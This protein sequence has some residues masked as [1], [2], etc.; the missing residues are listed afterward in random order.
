VGI[1]LGGFLILF[2]SR[3]PDTSSAGSNYRWCVVPNSNLVASLVGVA[4]ISPTDVW[5]VGSNNQGKTFTEHWNG[6]RWQVVASPNAGKQ[7]NILNAVVAVSTDDVW[8]VGETFGYAGETLVEHWNG[9]QW[10]IVSSPNRHPESYNNRLVSVAAI[11]ANDIWA[12][13]ESDNYS[14]KA[15]DN[16]RSGETLIEHWDGKQWSIISS[17][18]P[19]RVGSFLDGVAASSA[20][21]VWAVGE[22]VASG[23][24]LIEHWNGK[25]WSIVQSPK[26]KANYAGLRAIAVL[27]ADNIWTVG[28]QSSGDA[29]I[30]HWNGERWNLVSSPAAGKGIVDI[31]NAVSAISANDIWAVGGY[32]NTLIM[33]WDGK[34]WNTVGSAHLKTTMNSLGGVAGTSAEHVWTV[35]VSTNGGR[36]SPL[37]ETLC[38]S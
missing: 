32:S 21:D 1:I 18:N 35:G 31:L 4:A 38:G 8:A 2:N 28:F 16:N 19:G 20:A 6:K 13:G 22:P 26:L 37:I 15:P 29:L 36:V 27:S 33:H 17:P 10:S 3:H 24:P 7:Q 14:L 12:V 23:G 34:Q 5:A 11:S 9:K 30:E 25:Q